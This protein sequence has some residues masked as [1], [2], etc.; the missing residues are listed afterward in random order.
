MLKQIEK[1]M[2]VAVISLGYAVIIYTCIY[3]KDEPLNSN[4]FKSVI[5]A[6]NGN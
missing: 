1:F 5:K 3:E 2:W 6:T 4:T